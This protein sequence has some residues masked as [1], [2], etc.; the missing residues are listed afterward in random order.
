MTLKT[1]L[2]VSW[3]VCSLGIVYSKPP[4]IVFI[5][6]DDQDVVLGGMVRFV[7]FFL[8]FDLSWKSCELTMFIDVSSDVIFYK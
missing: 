5:L 6:T 8:K 7:Q 3:T 2:L 1:V 4:N